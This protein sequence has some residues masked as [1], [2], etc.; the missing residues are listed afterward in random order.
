MTMDQITPRT[1]PIAQPKRNPNQPGKAG[2][3]DRSNSLN[4]VDDFQPNPFAPIQLIPNPNGGAPIQVAPPPHGIKVEMAARE[5]GYQGHINRVQTGE[6][7]LL[8]QQRMAELGLRSTPLT[9]ENARGAVEQYTQNHS[10]ALML[11]AGAELQSQTNGG[12]HQ[13]VTTFS[14]GAGASASA[15]NLYNQARLGWTPPEQGEDANSME[16]QMGAQVMRNLASAYGVKPEDLTSSDPQVSGPA[17]ARLQ[18]GLVDQTSQAANSR[19]VQ[20]FHQGYAETV[21]RYEAGNNSVVHSAGNE[22]DLIQQMQADNGGRPIQVPPNF[23]RSALE[24]PDTTPVGALAFNADNSPRVASYSSGGNQVPIIAYA[25]A[26]D[27]QPGTSYAAPRV[28][29]MMQ[30]LHRR[31][32]NMTSE[33]VQ[34]RLLQQHTTP[35][36]GTHALTL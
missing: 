29:A 13:A 22:G 14:L 36:E 17:R 11:Q 10:M 7:P 27:G 8:M 20:N 23:F 4:I 26:M 12:T 1:Q 19:P 32:R 6:N 28:G 30:E 24:T 21:R 35:V 5:T 3:V 18:Q 31:D 33:Q 16:R 9:P 15:G 25:R 2:G 34:Q